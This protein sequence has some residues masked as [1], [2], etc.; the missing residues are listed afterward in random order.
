MLQVDV[1]LGAEEMVEKLT[2]KNLELEEQIQELQERANDLVSNVGTNSLYLS[3][4]SSF[5]KALPFLFVLLYPIGGA[6]G[7]Q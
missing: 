1:A 5:S 2:E 7:T 6:K 4:V 3:H